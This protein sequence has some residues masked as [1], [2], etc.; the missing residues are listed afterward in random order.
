MLLAISFRDISKFCGFPL[1]PVF[2]VVAST[3]HV[4]LGTRNTPR[5]AGPDSHGQCVKPTER[6][7]T[8]PFARRGQDLKTPLQS[9]LVW[10]AMRYSRRGKEKEIIKTILNWDFILKRSKHVV[11]MMN[12]ISSGEHRPLLSYLIIAT[13]EKNIYGKKALCRYMS[14]FVGKM[15]GGRFS[16]P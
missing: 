15:T 8:G 11:V 9:S 12:N 2:I 1:H 7:I 16:R 6:K 3:T 5:T 14:T 4:E 10:A 13:I